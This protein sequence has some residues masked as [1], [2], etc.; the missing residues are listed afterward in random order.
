MAA[1]SFLN[2]PVLAATLLVA[3]LLLG[4]GQPTAHRK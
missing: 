4:A 3:P 2:S 1:Y